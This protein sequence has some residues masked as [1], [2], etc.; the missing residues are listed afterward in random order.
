VSNQGRL[1]LS[2]KHICIIYKIYIFF[3]AYF[4]CNLYCGIIL[5]TFIMFL[6]KDITMYEYNACCLNRY[7]KKINNNKKVS[8]PGFE[9][10]GPGVEKSL[11]VSTYDV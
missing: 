3:K 2:L 5:C 6:R 1:H 11:K 4:V 10:G 7:A 9:G 8:D